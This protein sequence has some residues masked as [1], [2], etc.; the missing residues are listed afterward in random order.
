[1]RQATSCPSCAAYARDPKSGAITKGC[2]DCVVRSLARSPAFFRARTAGRITHEYR[3]T[4]A[5]VFGDAI[6]QVHDLVKAAYETHQRRIGHGD[7]Q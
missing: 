5:L 2:P 1:M 4:L 3:E 7:S 6:S